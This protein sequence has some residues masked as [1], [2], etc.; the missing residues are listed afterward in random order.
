MKSYRLNINSS[1]EP[2]KKLPAAIMAARESRSGD[3]RFNTIGR[4]SHYLSDAIVIVIFNSPVADWITLLISPCVGKIVRRIV[5]YKSNHY[6]LY[7][8]GVHG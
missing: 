7:F 2:R 8:D 1:I 3:L 4:F 5:R 6:T